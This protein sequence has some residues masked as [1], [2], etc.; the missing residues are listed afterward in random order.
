MNSTIKPLSCLAEQLKRACCNRDKLECLNR[1]PLVDHFIKQA[2]P[3]S[4]LLEQC[5]PEEELIIKSIVAIGQFH[6]V[7]PIDCVESEDLEVLIQNLIPVERFYREIGG[8]VG[9]HV[10]LLEQMGNAIGALPAQAGTVIK[11]WIYHRP[12]GIDLFQDTQ[13]V[14]NYVL[15]GIKAL[16]IMAEI[17]PVGG[18]ADRLRLYDSQTKMPLPAAKFY[19]C[20]KSLLE[21]MVEDLQAREY[22]YYQLYGVQVTVP[23]A[24]MTSQ[25]KDNHAQ[26]LKLCESK[27]W[28]G[29]SAD[30]FRLFCQPAVP[31]I[32]KQGNWF[33][34][35][36]LKPLMKPGGHGVIW[37][38]A[39]DQ[40]IFDWL[41]SLGREKLLVRQIN[42]PIAGCDDG[43]AVLTGV[44]CQDNRA[45]G[46]ASC[47]RQVNAAEGIN[48]VIE[49]QRDGNVQ[50]CLTNIEY[51]DFY[52]F[53]IQDVPIEE[54][55]CYSQF[56]SN[57]NLLFA[58]I[59]KISEAVEKCPIPGMIVNLK[60]MVFQ[61]QEGI[62]QEAEVARLESTMQNIADCFTEPSTFLTYNHRHKTISTIK[63]EWTPGSLL[64]ETAE[65]CSW[66]LYQNAQD[67]LKNYCSFNLPLLPSQEE[68]IQSGAAYQFLY[69]PGLGPFYSIIAQKLRGGMIH[70]GS[71]LHLKIAALDCEQL[72]L[73]GSLQIEAKDPL[74][75]WE[76][77]LCYSPRGGRCR[78]INV[79]VMNQGLYQGTSAQYW[80]PMEEGKEQ[81]H[82]ILHG[83]S[84]F[85]AHDLTFRGSFHLEVKSG[86]RM[87]AFEREGE[88][89]FEEMPLNDHRWY[90]KYT[91]DD[92]N[93]IRIHRSSSSL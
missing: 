59:Q 87:T 47:L 29:R 61:D 76:Q 74:G 70:A 6:Q 4:R 51:C 23:I 60:P 92:V 89:H 38:L 41:A 58:D 65:G 2:G 85:E 5:Q 39:K 17:Y 36:P 83:D 80:T 57:T 37:K 90:W 9:Y 71:R 52:R 3:I 48:V 16:P 22:V 88:I 62:I 33:M 20:G 42:N 21:W 82:I 28:F 73:Q 49:K 69:H 34:Q 13:E 53:G 7:F 78:L 93:E 32:D 35:G 18:A 26:I 46:F 91:V 24:M 68:Y 44:G 1:A 63:K 31:A 27:H 11:E 54:G 67:L 40:G 50:R 81:C 64:L 77:H 66:D 86:Y 75:H 15:S 56:P 25:E 43:L 10:V 14:R 30:S 79:R 19:F 45:F 84:E 8:L 55:N 12:E 72:E